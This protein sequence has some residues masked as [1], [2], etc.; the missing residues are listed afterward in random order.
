MTIHSYTNKEAEE[1][2]RKQDAARKRFEQEGRRH[3]LCR[4]ALLLALIALGLVGA[5]VWLH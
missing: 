1:M 2:R 4:V 3:W 5:S